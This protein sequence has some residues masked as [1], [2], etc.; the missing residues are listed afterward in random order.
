[1]TTTATR[2][3][4]LAHR[5]HRRRPD[6]RVTLGSGRYR[7]VDACYEKRS[8]AVSSNVHPAGFDE[9]M[10]KTLATATATATVDRLL[11]HAQLNRWGDPTSLHGDNRGHPRGDRL[12]ARA[13]TVMTVDA[14]PAPGAFRASSP[15]CPCRTPIA[16]DGPMRKL[17][18]ICEP[19]GLV[20]GECDFI[21]W[22][23][24]SPSRK[25]RSPSARIIPW[26]P[27]GRAFR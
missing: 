24:I 27:A 25:D 9:I 12:T 2:L 23:P 17:A 10:L 1:M 5:G 13:K 26:A 18:G 6:P 8:L 14:V 11:H 20:S 7:L 15:R 21:A 4:L 3:A 19:V 22:R 16:K